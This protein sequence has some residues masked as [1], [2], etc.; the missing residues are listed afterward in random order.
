MET[1][2][3]A[4]ERERMRRHNL[5]EVPMLGMR[6]FSSAVLFLLVGFVGVGLV[7]ANVDGN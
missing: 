5:K 3:R 7:K 1:T 2:R 4:E 6:V